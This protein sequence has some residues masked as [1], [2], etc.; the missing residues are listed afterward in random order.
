MRP[1]GALA[2]WGSIQAV[3]G[4]FGTTTEPSYEKGKAREMI[5]LE[6]LGCFRL[7]EGK[8]LGAGGVGETRCPSRKK[9]V[10]PHGDDSNGGGEL[11]L[12]I[13]ASEDHKPLGVSSAEACGTVRGGNSILS[14]PA[15]Q[16]LIPMPGD[17]RTTKN[18]SQKKGFPACC[19][20]IWD[21]W[22]V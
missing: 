19:F 3:G 12:C 18:S 13:F 1:Q 6:A 22:R 20:W 8:M 5:W 21:Q 2:G 15:L 7:G 4:L 10:P 11:L 9:A 14:P 17:L 16:R